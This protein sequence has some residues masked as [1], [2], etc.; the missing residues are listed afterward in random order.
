[1]I[2]IKPQSSNC[3]NFRI[4]NIYFSI[5]LKNSLTSCI[6]DS[7]ADISLIKANSIR[8]GI[9]IWPRSAVQINGIAYDSKPI[10]TIGTVEA[11][12]LINDT[13][14]HHQFQVVH[15]ND[16]RMKEDALLGMDFLQANNVRIDFG[17]N[18]LITFSPSIAINEK[19]LQD[20]LSENQADKLIIPNKENINKLSNKKMNEITKLNKTENDIHLLETSSPDNQENFMNKVQKPNKN[21]IINEDNLLEQFPVEN[22]ALKKYMRKVNEV[23]K[24][25]PNH[26]LKNPSNFCY[27]NSLFQ[28]LFADLISISTKHSHSLNKKRS[29][30]FCIECLI[31]K[32]KGLMAVKQ[33]AFV[34]IQFHSWIT[35][36]CNLN[37]SKNLHEDV[38]EILKSLFAL[39]KSEKPT[40]PPTGFLEEL[41]GKFQ[42][43]IKCSICKSSSSSSILF[44]D[45]SVDVDSTLTNS[46][47]Q[48]FSSQLLSD[49]VCLTCNSMN[50]SVSSLQILSLPTVLTIHIKRFTNDNE[51]NSE[52]ILIP[53]TLNLSQFISNKMKPSST[54]YEI[55]SIINHI[56][57][58]ANKG[59]YNTIRMLPNNIGFSYDDDKVN[60]VSTDKIQSKDAYLLFYKKCPVELDKFSIKQ[61]SIDKTAENDTRTQS[62]LNNIKTD[63]LDQKFSNQIQNLLTEF[64][65]VFHVKGDMLSSCAIVKHDIPLYTDTA[66]IN[67][68]NYRLPFSQRE[69]I[70]RQVDELLEQEI[71]ETST[72]P[73]NSPLLLVPKKGLDENGK[74]KQR[75]V[76]DYRLINEKTIPE[77][78]AVPQVVD[79]IDQ[80]HLAKVYSSIDLSSAFHQI[81]LEDQAKPKT[82]FSTAYGH[83]QFRRLPFGLKTASHSLSRA[84]LLA[85]HD[86]IGKILFLYLDDLII[87]APTMEEHITRLRIV[88]QRLRDVNLKA[89]PKKSEICKSQI[90]FL[91][92]IISD[93]G[94]TPNPEK[95][96]SIAKIP[97]PHT[98]RAIRSFL[99]LLNYYRRYIPAFSEK[100]KPLNNLLRK[101]LKFTWTSECETAFEFFKNIL[102]NPPI[103]QYPDFTKTFNITCDASFTAL[104]AVLSQGPLGEDLPIAFASRTLSDV[105]TRYGATE[106]ELLSIVYAIQ[107]FHCYIY[108][109][110]FQVFSDS[111]ALQWLFQVKSPTSRLIRWKLYLANYDFEIIHVKGKANVVADCLSRYIQPP[112]IKTVNMLTRAKTK[113]LTA[114]AKPAI[115]SRQLTFENKMKKVPIQDVPLIIESCDE[116][117]LKI[118][119]FSIKILN[120]DNI[121]MISHLGLTHSDIRT[122][123][124]IADLKQNQFF[125]VNNTRSNTTINFEN[126]HTNLTTLTA[127]LS[128][129]EIDKVSFF[130]S[131]FSNTNKEYRQLKTM[132]YEIFD[133]TNVKI[134]CLIK[135]ITTLIHQDEIEQV[136][137]DFHD[138]PLSGH[139]GVNRMI[140]RISNQFKW[141]GLSRD[142]KNYVRKCPSC[143]VTKSSNKNK[144]PMAI[145]STSHT[146]FYCVSI[147]VVGPLVTSRENFKYVL[148]FQDDLTKYFG[149]IAIENHEADTVAKHFVNEIVLRF[150]L[151]QDLRSDRGS[152]FLSDLFSRV[153]KL[154][155]IKRRATSAY[156]PQSNGALE[157]S[158]RT[159]KSMLRAY[160]EKDKTNWPEFLPFVVFVIN[161]TKNRSIGYSSH[162]LLYGYQLD[163]PSNLKRKPEPVYTYDDYANELKFKMQVAHEI[164]REHL[165]ESKINN[166]LYYD[167][168][169]NLDEYDVGDQILIQNNQR[170]TKLDNLFLG[171]YEIIEILSDTNVKIKIGKKFKVVHKDRIKKFYE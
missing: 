126:L 109:T 56:G 159:L 27:A 24:Y 108:L 121:K 32:I 138:S 73:F 74:P 72:S 94:V 154:L 45:I 160:I 36:H 105:E 93:K 58:E 28:A 162:Q 29:K 70:Q 130:K 18:T 48:Y 115:T 127:L 166:K 134:F 168:N 83:F 47:E 37:A 57:N 113:K 135:E 128:K 104:S 10:I 3:K 63:H 95:V 133:N 87:F 152:E 16:L 1:M 59:H 9:N 169:A 102:I 35:R 148:T 76:F 140:S 129:F 22:Q 146:P 42:T 20:K 31:V 86:L 34:P 12:V 25:V 54:K 13:I 23:T 15:D 137:K 151:P 89:C 84:M 118:Y 71:I 114:I 107:E 167:D 66:P 112:P 33:E 142:I 50:S 101:D 69:E 41:W 67:V 39:S 78:F 46:I 170:K 149:A 81:L 144:Q 55:S 96:E 116:N 82:A 122:G 163:V 155:G 8:D 11:D 79:I 19:P 164:A 171:P 30:S 38:H 141:L 52:E 131:D 51:K 161:T 97:R 88:F 111:K 123:E 7:G 136:L 158:H 150:G 98:Q 120:I 99:G 53:H 64:S 139:Q 77:S 132:L 17:P 60:E 68:K 21:V 106:I 103:L 4:L 6:L 44:N 156:R 100:A 14:I 92:H 117:L 157:R 165:I 40:K 124:V 2:N 90:L 143:Q 62:L 5:G 85:M 145:T 80:L 61:L 147:D 65:D 43:H 119:K 110:K 125:L 49:F 75:L 91:G 153:L 26:G